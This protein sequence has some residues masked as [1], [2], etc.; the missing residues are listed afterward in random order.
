MSTKPPVQG[1]TK[2]GT[3]HFGSIA[4]DLDDAGKEYTYT[5]TEY[6]SNEFGSGWAAASNPV[7]VKVK[8]GA[9]TGT[10]TLN[11]TCDPADFTAN[12]S[13]NYTAKGEAVLKVK[14]ELKGADWPAGRSITFTLT[15]QSGAPMP[16]GCSA[17][18]ACTVTLNNVPGT[19]SFEKISYSFADAGKTYTYTISE[20]ISGFG[21]WSAVQNPVTVQVKVTDDGTGKLDVKGTPED[22]TALF[23][24]VYKAA[25][26]EGEIKVIKILTG[27]DWQDGDSFTFTL[28]GLNNAPMPSNTTITIDNK[29]TDH[30]A[31]FGPI[32]FDK[33]GTYFYTVT[34]TRGSITGIIY[35]ESVHI[36]T[37]SVTDDGQGQLVAQTPKVEVENLYV[38]PVEGQ[39]SVEK[40]LSGRGWKDGDSFTFTLEGLNNA[41]MPAVTQ[42]T[43]DNKDPDHIL[44][45]GT[46]KFT[47]AGTYVYSVT[48]TKGSIE[49]ITYDESKHTVVIIVENDNNGSLTAGAGTVLDPKVIITNTYVVTPVC[50]QFGGCKSFPNAPDD[51]KS[52][53]FTY[54]LLQD[55]REIDTAVTKGA[56]GYQFD[57]FIYS[58]PGTYRYLVEEKAGDVYGIEYDRNKYDVIVTVELDDS[59]GKLTAKIT[60]PD[61]NPINN[62]NGMNFNNPYTASASV[63]IEAVKEISGADWPAGG[64]V[65]FMIE[66]VDDAPLPAK[67]TVTITGP[68]TAVFD[69]IRYGIKDAGKVYQY[70]VTESA[71]GFPG[72][73]SVSPVS[74][75]V[76]VN[77]SREDGGPIRADVT[78][79]QG[80]LITNTYNDAHIQFQGSKILK[81]GILESNMFRFILD[82][83]DGTHQVV[84]NIGYSFTFEPIWFTDPGEYT[85]TIREEADPGGNIT[86]DPMVYTIVVTVL[87]DDHGDP[88]VDSV[89]N[90][91]KK[92]VFVNGYHSDPPVPPAPPGGTPDIPGRLPDT[93]FSAMHVT[94]LPEM[95]KDL[96]YKPLRMMLEIPSLALST[97]I[98]SVPEVDGSY[99]VT[100]LGNK[101]GA[102]EGYAKPGEGRAILTG[103]NH[104]DDKEAG[105]FAFLLDLNKGDRV[106][107]NRTGYGL[108]I[109]TVYANEKIGAYD[110]ER[111]EQISAEFEN[112]IT[113]ITCEDELEGGGYA[114]RRIVAVRPL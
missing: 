96:N 105:P 72:G 68:G 101:A 23:T 2:A 66:G 29:I 63:S 85:Y 4:Y 21:G 12:F 90:N 16:A 5:V 7:T 114:N 106:F 33:A 94:D 59:T 83:S 19:A 61:G 52:T 45:F 65:T 93:G 77:V 37:L 103:H 13:N 18:T 70:I 64:T 81:G 112:S 92:I 58:E 44:S 73:W 97:E 48:E 102:L 41:P 14:K 46:I 32:P 60:D 95:P 49:G 75:P 24:N 8:V 56:G 36:V 17:S 38:K 74:F 15:G 55:G 47:E 26:T 71:D 27:R 69:P 80:N 78:Y 91:S 98:V 109:Y 104:L 89:S 9:D 84:S 62:S 67:N 113:M 10:G 39:I 25:P 35:D 40:K 108:Q 3:N 87:V 110:Q 1:L 99:P 22:L 6:F 57:P 51:L 53:E 30:A 79:V 11:V 42:I 86:Y 20:D 88:Y 31:F 43:I 34:E 111:L 100:W 28:A 107:L 50:V 54:R 82:G 76:T